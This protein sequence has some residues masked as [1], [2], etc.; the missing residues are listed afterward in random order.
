MHFDER[1]VT[2]EK[3][4][5]R[6]GFASMSPERRRAIASMGGHAAHAEGVAHVWDS[7]AARIA[8]SKG[9][10]NRWKNRPKTAA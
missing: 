10:K 7:A 8:G 4:K 1:V 9:G 2:G 6:Q 5:G 3:P